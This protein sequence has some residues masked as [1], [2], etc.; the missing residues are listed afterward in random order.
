M[1]W[2]EYLIT[3]FM[4]KTCGTCLN[5]DGHRED[6]G[7]PLNSSWAGLVRWRADCPCA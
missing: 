4:P 1:C 6:K 2:M 3:H 5:Q 7:L